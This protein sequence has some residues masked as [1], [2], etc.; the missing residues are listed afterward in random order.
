MATSRASQLE[1]LLGQCRAETF[2]KGLE[3]QHAGGR[4]AIVQQRNEELMQQVCVF[5]YGEG[6]CVW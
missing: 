2:R 6:V 5:V 4:I 3:G 1:T